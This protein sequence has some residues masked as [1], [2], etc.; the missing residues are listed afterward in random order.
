MKKQLGLL[1]VS[2][3]IC[4]IGCFGGCEQL[5][6][7]LGMKPDHVT[8]NVMVAVYVRLVDADNIPVSTSVDGV[9]MFIEMT[10]QGTDRLV[11][12]RI[13]QGGLCQATGSY[14][15]SKGQWIN[16]TASIQKSYQGFFPVGPVSTRLTW[17]TVNAST[18]VVDVYN[19]YPELTITMK[20]QSII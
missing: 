3:L 6:E 11:F 7:Q 5:G 15:M 19:W 18:N 20:K 2:V 16:C 13:V 8:V 4:M 14:T 10:R 9:S 17:D 12:D 1:G